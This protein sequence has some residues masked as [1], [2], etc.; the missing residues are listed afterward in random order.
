MKQKIFKIIGVLAIVL[1]TLVLGAITYI[2]VFT[3]TSINL[4]KPFQSLSGFTN[5]IRNIVGVNGFVSFILVLLIFILFAR[6]IE[7]KENKEIE[8]Y[9]EKHSAEK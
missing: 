7:F 1:F 6:W 2:L 9:N 5:P 8:K 3:V 4:S